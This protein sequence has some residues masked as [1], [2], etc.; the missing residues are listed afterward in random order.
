M[1]NNKDKM[2]KDEFLQNV[3]ARSA[4]NQ[5]DVGKV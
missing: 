5:E 4:V 1:D 2:N 3:A